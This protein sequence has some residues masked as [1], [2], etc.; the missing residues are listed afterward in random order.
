[1]GSHVIPTPATG[2]EPARNWPVF[3]PILHEAVQYFHMPVHV[4]ARIGTS[5]N[6]LP[7]INAIRAE[8]ADVRRSLARNQE[9]LE[10]LLAAHS[11]SSD[12]EIQ[13]EEVGDD[14]AR[15]RILTLFENSSASL[16]YDDISERLRLPLRQ[17]VEVCNQLE[18]EGLIGEPRPRQ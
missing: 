2:S 18:T 17:T 13:L 4:N 12:T 10:Q 5:E 9:L 1:M 8:I 3:R 6:L 7:I 11:G 16:F 15:R 14:E